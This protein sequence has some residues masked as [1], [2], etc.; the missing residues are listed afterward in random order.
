MQQHIYLIGDRTFLKETDD[1][2]K[3]IFMQSTTK[4]RMLD[5]THRGV[6]IMPDGDD[7]GFNNKEL[8][9]AN[10]VDKFGATTPEELHEALAT[11]NFFK[12]GGGGVSEKLT[13]F[14]VRGTTL[15]K[16]SDGDVVPEHETNNERWQYLGINSI[17]PVFN[18]PSL[19]LN[20]SP[21]TSNS[22]EVGEIL[23]LTLSRVYTQNDAGTEIATTYQKNNVD[24]AGNTDTIELTTTNVVYKAITSYNAGTGTKPDNLGTPV[25]NTIIAGSVTSNTRSFRG[26]L[27]IFYGN[28][29]SKNTTGATIRAN[30]TKR[31][32]NSGNVFNLDTG[33]TNSIFQIWL[34]TG[35][36]LVSVIDLDA[37]NFD[38]T[39]SYSSESQTG[40]DANSNALTG[41]LYTFTQSVPY[42]ENHRHQITIS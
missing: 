9:L 23:N 17:P 6:M 26:Y 24:L 35:T 18:L 7:D 42:S 29:A 27:P 30:L 38:V 37:L 19:V 13:S 28:T 33:S 32:T 2:G 36:T 8:I 11:N 16:A 10:L 40:L 4:P 5:I 20:T 14:T 15:G 1:N 21:S 39:A 34:P 22:R 3:L 31:L 12:K 25:A 41:T